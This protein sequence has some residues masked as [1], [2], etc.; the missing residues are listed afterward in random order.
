M[1]LKVVLI[2]S[3]L[4]GCAYQASYAQEL[5]YPLEI[6]EE[7]HTLK[8]ANRLLDNSEKW[9]SCADGQ[10]ISVGFYAERLVIDTVGRSND[11]HEILSA[12]YIDLYIDFRNECRVVQLPNLFTGDHTP[13]V[14]RIDKPRYK[15][16]AWLLK[17][18]WY[19]GRHRYTFW[20][21]DPFF[22]VNAWSPHISVLCE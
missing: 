22:A 10:R 9:L 8:F 21:Q 11:C 14:V 18:R 12:K 13:L 2:I 15:R 7:S 5:V 16:F 17:P 1:N 19:F 6:H 3:N 4:V 20:Y